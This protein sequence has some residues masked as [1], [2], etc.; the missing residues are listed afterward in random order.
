[1]RL[2]ASI[3]IVAFL[4]LAVFSAMAC[5]RKGPSE[6]DLHRSPM[7]QGTPPEKTT[8][9]SPKDLHDPV[10]P[11]YKSA[12]VQHKKTPSRLVWV[13]SV[14]QAIQM[15]SGTKNK[16][17][18]IIYYA[19]QAPCEECRVIEEKVFSDPAVLKQSE[20]WVFVRVNIDVQLELAKYNHI[21][22]VPAFQF[23]DHMGHA[24]KTYQGSVTPEQFAEML[25]TWY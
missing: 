24:Y 22:K 20:R 2:V 9:K 21:E 19:S 17:K 10:Q 7:Q 5:S 6:E 25:L 4:F 12:Y 15:T 23:L 3:S 8:L 13:S 11:G 18:A 1:M 14:E 16:K